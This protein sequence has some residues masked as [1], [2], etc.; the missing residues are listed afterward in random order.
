MAEVQDMKSPFPGMD[1]FIE[2]CGMWEDFHDK[3]IG[4]IE[5]V[6]APELPKGYAARVRKRSYVLLIED[7]EKVKRPFIPD[8]SVTTD[9]GRK[10]TRPA[11]AT[12][13]GSPLTTEGVV[14]MRA[15]IEEEFD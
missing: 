11:A 1:P 5:R 10:G 12:T 2:M 7:E 6:L 8:V 15:F 4:E 13:S 14:S 9:R 3:L